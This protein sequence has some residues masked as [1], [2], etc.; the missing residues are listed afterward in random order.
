V[1]VKD[2]LQCLEVTNSPV[3]CFLFRGKIFPNEV[4]NSQ[5]CISELVMV[6]CHNEAANISANFVVFGLLA[7]KVA[8]ASLQ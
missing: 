2:C 1:V 6:F 5:H 4:F 3:K 8:C 7:A